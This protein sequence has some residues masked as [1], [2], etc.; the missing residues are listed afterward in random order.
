M[1]VIT[2]QVFSFSSGNGIQLR[3][4]ELIRPIQ[5]GD[6]WTKL[7]VA[8][9]YGISGLGAYT[10][11]FDVGLCTAGARGIGSNNPLN[12]I[13]LGYCGGTTGRLS[14]G[15]DDYAPLLT[16]SW[17]Y[18]NTSY[19]HAL[20]QHG[21]T[22]VSYN[23]EQTDHFVHSTEP[24]AGAYRR[25]LVIFDYRRIGTACTLYRYPGRL[26]ADNAPMACDYS[27]TDLVSISELAFG[28]G[29][30]VTNVVYPYNRQT[31][32]FDPV[33]FTSYA[34]YSFSYDPSYGP[35]NAVNIAWA[36]T[37]QTLTIWGIA[38]SKHG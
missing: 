33:N 38:V 2:Q 8:L 34:P 3:S 36:T 1:A 5:I 11:L 25:G 31:G 20:W 17:P 16:N 32:L 10:S 22:A 28:L 9:L 19:T 24:K 37:V 7:R 21:S 12:Y 30:G 4:E 14:G 26:G 23:R 18:Y 6:N 13:G 27:M 35:L 29:N 15:A